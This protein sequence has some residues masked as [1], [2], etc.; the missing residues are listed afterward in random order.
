VVVQEPALD[1]L[2]DVVAAD[3]A[4]R[5]SRRGRCGCDGEGLF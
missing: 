4:E 1:G 5:R 3:R 2:D